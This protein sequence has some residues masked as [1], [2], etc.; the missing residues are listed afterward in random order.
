MTAQLI[1]LT[2]KAR[3][4]LDPPVQPEDLFTPAQLAA[5][6]EAGYR[7]EGCT[8]SPQNECD[9][10]AWTDAGAAFDQA[11]DAEWYV[12]EFGEF[13]FEHAP[14]CHECGATLLDDDSPDGL[15]E[16]CVDETVLG[17]S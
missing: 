15:C 11:I 7:V 16:A 10:Y 14:R 17:A 8:D 4:L 13:C 3:S 2:D 12:G 6:V 9:Y 1:A 5:L